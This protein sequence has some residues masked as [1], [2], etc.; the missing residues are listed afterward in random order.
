MLGGNSLMRRR[1]SSVI[2]DD[3]SNALMTKTKELFYMCDPT[4]KGYVTKDELY[5]LKDELGLEDHEVENAF[6]QLDTDKDKYLTIE[7]F[8]TGFG[9][10]L[11]I[12]SP[13]IEKVNDELKPDFAF[14][15]FNL[16]DREDKG[17]ITKQDFI[18][19]AATLEI[20]STRV[21]HLVNRLRKSS[22]VIRFDEFVNNIGSVV[23]LSPALQGIE[24]NLNREKI[25]TIKRKILSQ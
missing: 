6:D 15:V 24:Q 1:H 3:I 19:S 8:T 10:F 2:G 5:R 13:T 22:E 20:E 4:N 7:E 9:L 23:A 17:Y 25:I 14:Q 12:E 21:D 16:I 18:D 11:G